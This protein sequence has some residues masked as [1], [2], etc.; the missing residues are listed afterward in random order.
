VNTAVLRQEPGFPSFVAIAPGISRVVFGPVRIATTG[1]S[2]STELSACRD[3]GVPASEC[4]H[5]PMVVEVAPTASPLAS[6]S[7]ASP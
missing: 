7:P 1:A 2:G 3:E 6:G 4:V 5:V